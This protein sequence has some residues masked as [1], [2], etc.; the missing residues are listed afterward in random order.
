MCVCVCGKAVKFDNVQSAAES[1]R[2]VSSVLHKELKAPLIPSPLLIICVVKKREKKEEA[3][4][5]DAILNELGR[6]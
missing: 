6:E 4:K 2:A 5:L 1:Y 3:K